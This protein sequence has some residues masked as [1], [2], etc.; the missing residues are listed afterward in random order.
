MTKNIILTL[1]VLAIAFTATSASAAV[2]ST[3]TSEAKNGEP[4]TGPLIVAASGDLLETVGS[5]AAESASGSSNRQ[6]T[7]SVFDGQI[8]TS[9][10]N[11]PSPATDGGYW[12][13]GHFIEIDLDTTTNTLG[14]DI[15]SITVIQ[16]GD[17]YRPGHGYTVQ[18]RT[19]G[20]S[21]ADILTVSGG[22]GGNVNE[23]VISNNSGPLVETGVDGIRFNFA[24]S[25]NGYGW[26]V[27]RE[28]DAIG[29]ATVPEPAT[30]S[31]LALGGL[32]L[33][34]RRRR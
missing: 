33:L 24:D 17:G 21:F 26:T 6:N 4:H 29:T 25:G 13:P 1:A 23:I 7:A 10:S 14:Y 12:G 27:Y 3:L 30:M 32:G 16:C 15:S 20:G 11:T 22:T 19:V 5:V 18:L 31:L 28:L 9:I 8:T 34:R 2:I